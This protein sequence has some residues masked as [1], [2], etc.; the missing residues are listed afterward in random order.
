MIRRPPRS[1]LFPYTTLFRSTDRDGVPTR[2]VEMVRHTL[3]ETGPKVQATRMVRDYVQQLYVPAARSA[4]VMAEGGYAPARD[5]AGWRARLLDRWSTVRAAHVE[6]TGAGD[7]PEIGST[8]ALR[9]EVELPGLTP[10][11]VQVQDRKSVV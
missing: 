2:W 7:T 1:T 6:A 8:L 5:E 3:R 10:S 4:R 11:D 9:A